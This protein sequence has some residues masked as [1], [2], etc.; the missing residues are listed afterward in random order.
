MP[1]FSI[2]DGPVI[3]Y[4]DTGDNG[5]PS[6][7]PII[8][9]HGLFMSRHMFG[10]QLEEFSRDHRCIVWDERAHGDTVWEGDFTYW[11]SA[12]DL[13]ALADHLGIDRFIHVG[14]SQGGLLALRAAMLD[15]TRF[16]G[17][18]QLSTQAGGLAGEEEQAFRAIIA[19]WTE[20]GPTP[21]KLDFLDWLIL[22]PGA[23]SKF[24]R[25]YWS[26][27]TPQQINDATYALYDA[28]SVEDRLGE[29]TA[30]LIVIHGLVDVSTPLE[31]AILVSERAPDC[32]GLTLVENGPHVCNLTH[33]DIV[34]SAC[35]T[36]ID[37]VSAEYLATL[38]P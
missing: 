28:K 9:S 10:P 30:P 6:R 14:F 27:L 29:V 31:R 11:D 20:L 3:S 1:T 21:E 35:R 26:T 12:R 37:E 15:P 38:A 16:I 19:E 5:D 25:D 34:N 24:W 32:R 4:E 7:V 33:V 8:F 2:P 18:V 17:M 36:F 22:G 13:F 23:D